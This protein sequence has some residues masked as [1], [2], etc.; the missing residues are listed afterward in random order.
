MNGIVDED[1]STAEPA[2]SEEFLR[3]EKVM[4]KFAASSEFKRLKEHFGLRIEFYKNYLP[5]GQA[6][7]ECTTEERGYMWLAATA[8]IGEMNS[9]INSYENAAES[10]K[11]AK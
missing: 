10:V 5:S 3:T 7:T 11:N 4:A 6:L 2:V 1:F 8:I 9:V